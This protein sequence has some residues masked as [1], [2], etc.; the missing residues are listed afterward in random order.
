LFDGP[1]GCAEMSVLW[2]PVT[3]LFGEVATWTET[4]GH[5]LNVD[6]K[7]PCISILIQN[8]AYLHII[9]IFLCYLKIIII[10][11]SLTL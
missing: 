11:R 6:Y 5:M 2:F 3:L 1:Y 8:L 10:Y 9:E 7:C 4:E